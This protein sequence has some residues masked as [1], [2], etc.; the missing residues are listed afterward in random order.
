MTT[1]T[2]EDGN[3]NNILD[4]V[5]QPGWSYIIDHDNVVDNEAEADAD[6]E[7][8]SDDEDQVTPGFIVPTRVQTGRPGVYQASSPTLPANTR[9]FGAIGHSPFDDE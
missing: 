2:V 3:G 1:I 5:L 7:N 6:Y 4:L 8:N 9:I